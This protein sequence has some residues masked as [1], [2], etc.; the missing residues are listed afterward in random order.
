MVVEKIWQFFGNLECEN[1]TVD[2]KPTYFLQWGIFLKQFIRRNFG[3][4]MFVII[5]EFVISGVSDIPEAY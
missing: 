1:Y 4:K 5:Q 2:Y 3:K